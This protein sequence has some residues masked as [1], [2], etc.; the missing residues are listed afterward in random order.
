MNRQIET[1]AGYTKN[2]KKRF[3]KDLF[4]RFAIN[5]NDMN[6]DRIEK[7]DIVMVNF[8]NSQYTLCSNAEVLN[9]PQAAGDSWIFRDLMVDRLYYVSEGCTIELLH[10]CKE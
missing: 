7:G 1:T 6:P 3:Q 8:N 4:A 5:Q 2:L 9:I 10:K